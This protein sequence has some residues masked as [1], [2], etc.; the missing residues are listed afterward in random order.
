MI[1]G[2]S[3]GVSRKRLKPIIAEGKGKEI[4]VDVERGLEKKLLLIKPKLSKSKNIFGEEELTYLIGVSPAGKTIIE[5][6]N[7]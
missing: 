7:P 2:N 6:K 5:R 3:A 1:P 4:K